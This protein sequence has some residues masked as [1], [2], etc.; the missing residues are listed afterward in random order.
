MHVIRRDE[1]INKILSVVFLEIQG[2]QD[3]EMFQN[4]RFQ[5]SS[6]WQTV[7]HQGTQKVVTICNNENDYIIL[8]SEITFK[9][10]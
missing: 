5:I 2:L 1:S 3:S 7:N 8:F 6:L 9:I 10:S 4:S